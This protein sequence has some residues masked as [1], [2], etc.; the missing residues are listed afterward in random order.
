MD[1]EGDSPCAK[2]GGIW[3]TSVLSEQKPKTNLKLLYQ[4]KII[5]YKEKDLGLSADFATDSL[6]CSELVN[7]RDL[8]NCCY[9]RYLL[10]RFARETPG[11]RAL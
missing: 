8:V 1:S 7:L 3:E 11:V 5:N 4:V 10:P 2:T 6:S 9:E